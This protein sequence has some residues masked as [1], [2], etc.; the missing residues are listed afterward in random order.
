MN[1][2]QKILMILGTAFTAF[3]VIMTIC[4]T[5]VGSLQ[6]VQ[7]E[8][9]IWTVNS[10]SRTSWLIARVFFIARFSTIR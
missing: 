5:G 10:V 6:E 8:I 9:F 4:F 1:T 2:A 3:G 7:I